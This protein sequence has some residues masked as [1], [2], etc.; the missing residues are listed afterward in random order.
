L[1]TLLFEGGSDD[2]FGE[3][4]TRQEICNDATGRALQFEASTPDGCGVIV[5][6]CY[7]TEADSGV[8]LGKDGW[9]IGIESLRE[10]LPC[11]WPMRLIAGYGGYQ[12]RLEIDAPD[13]VN[14]KEI[15]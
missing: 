11:L 3:L 9:M 14:V 5:T 1:K 12:N 8:I 7:G 10:D 6:G 15:A 2:L 4:T 13:N